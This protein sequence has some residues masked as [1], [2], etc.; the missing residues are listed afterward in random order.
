MLPPFFLFVFVTWLCIQRK[1]CFLLY[2]P[3]R[4]KQLWETYVR[5]N[6]LIT[7]LSKSLHQFT[8]VQLFCYSFTRITSWRQTGTVS[9]FASANSLS[10]IALCAFSACPQHDVL[11]FPRSLFSSP[12]WI[13]FIYRWFF[14]N[15][16][17]KKTPKTQHPNCEKKKVKFFLL[18]EFY[19]SSNF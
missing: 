9:V 5:S 16:C 15:S 2:L 8:A 11:P 13:Y 19:L 4:Y 3:Y 17:F 1:L 12:I 10:F 6:G 7:R 18:T 14:V